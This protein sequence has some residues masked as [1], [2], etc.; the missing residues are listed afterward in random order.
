[1]LYFWNAGGSSISILII[2]SIWRSVPLSYGFHLFQ[3]EAVFPRVLDVTRGCVSSTSSTSS[4]ARGRGLLILI[5]SGS[6][7]FCVLLPSKL[8]SA[9]PAP[10]LLKSPTLGIRRRHFVRDNTL[11]EKWARTWSALKKRWVRYKY[12]NPWVQDE[13]RRTVMHTSLR[14]KKDFVGSNSNSY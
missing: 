6:V 3:C 12:W 4:S 1:M 9:C 7:S 13:W 5:I 10:L 8:F 11:Y 14:W 2:I